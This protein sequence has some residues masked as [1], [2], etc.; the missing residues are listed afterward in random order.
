MTNEEIGRLILQAGTGSHGNVAKKLADALV[1]VGQVGVKFPGLAS[2]LAKFADAE[3][4]AL[5]AGS[6]E[7]DSFML[8]A[9]MLH[10]F[11]MV[12]DEGDVYLCSSRQI[13]SLIRSVLSARDAQAASEPPVVAADITTDTQLPQ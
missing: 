3:A 10:G 5:Q 12:D 1:A 2:K 4:N 13:V 9:A 6:P 8:E 11:E 7:T